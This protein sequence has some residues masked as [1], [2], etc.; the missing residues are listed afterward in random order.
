MSTVMDRVD[1]PFGE[2]HGPMLTG[3]YAPIFDEQELR[4]LLVEGEIPADL[5][6]VY[7]RN[8]PN[9]R[10]EPKGNFH[11]FDGDGM[12]H[13]AEFRGGKVTYRNKWI[14]TQGWLR[15]DEAGQETFWGVMN[16]VKGRPDK[17]MNDVANTDVIGHGGNAV[18]TWYLAGVPYVVDPVT[19]ETRKAARD[20][21]FPPGNGMSA[22]PKVDE[23]SGELLFFDYFAEHPHMSYGVVDAQGKLVHHVPIELPGD[24]L[25]H[26]MGITENYTILH[27]LPV[28]HDEEA[29]RA[30]RHKIVFNSEIPARFG[31]I[32]RYGAS[33]S[34]RWF[35]FSSCFLYH[36][37]NCWEDGDEIV[38][39]ACRYMPA[40]HDDGSFDDQRTAKMIA[41][42][43]MDARLWRYRMNLKTGE[44]V[45]ECLDPDH[46]VEFPG[47]NSALTGRRTE[48]GYFVDHDPHILRWTGIRKMNTDTGETAGEWSDSH[49]HC[50]YSEP[51]F[52][53]AD[54]PE[55]EDHGYVVVFVWN[56]ETRVQQLQVFDALDIGKGP[57]ARVTLPQ[58]VP[59]G[60]H[61]CWMKPKQIENWHW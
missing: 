40:R 2:E 47:F 30:G 42:L 21:V 46:N 4:N 58:R 41:H 48:W 57:V 6:G 37:V 9:Q 24:R 14:R 54:N 12:L 33:D 56:D 51:W 15:N 53:P 38:M 35:E 19:L 27:D 1:A 11:I 55:S 39:V 49:E 43:V 10:F 29:L 50:W 8:G 26:D 25:P 20:Y 13:A 18:A 22:H 32:P 52:A 16:S 5:N 23:F 3:E 28:Y 7:L 44:A 45:E 61:A 60:F 34:I 59:P 36:V 17:P 31:V